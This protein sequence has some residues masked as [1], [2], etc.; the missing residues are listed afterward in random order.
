MVRISYSGAY[1]TVGNP[2][3]TPKARDLPG[4]AAFA[5]DKPEKFY[6]AFIDRHLDASRILILQGALG[7]DK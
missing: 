4:S 2:A 5:D 6:A 1:L 3:A 7:S